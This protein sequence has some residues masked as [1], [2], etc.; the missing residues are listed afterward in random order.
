M[1]RPLHRSLRR[2]G[3]SRKTS[4]ADQANKKHRESVSHFRASK[5]CFSL[6]TTNDLV[7]FFGQNFQLIWLNFTTR[8]KFLTYLVIFRGLIQVVFDQSL[9]LLRLKICVGQVFTVETYQILKNN[10]AFWSQ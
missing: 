1:V 2:M 4:C 9:N 8:S 7:A 5:C 3:S 6:I 10:L